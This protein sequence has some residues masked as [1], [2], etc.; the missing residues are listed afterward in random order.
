[1]SE[2]YYLKC[3]RTYVDEQYGHSDF[4]ESREYE[5]LELAEKRLKVL[6]EPRRHYQIMVVDSKTNMSVV[7]IR[8]REMYR[9]LYKSVLTELIK[10]L[11]EKIVKKA[12]D[13]EVS[14]PSW[15]RCEIFEN[16]GSIYFKMENNVGVYKL[17]LCDRKVIGTFEEDLDDLIKAVNRLVG[18]PVK[19]ISWDTWYDFSRCYYTDSEDEKGSVD[20]Y[21][22]FF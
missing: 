13:L 7:V 4:L 9:F 19:R 12:G 1:M 20:L 8:S 14:I 17:N 10:Q 11:L 5:S 3:Y 15:C 2:K 18:K 21:F 16:K 22:D 6:Y